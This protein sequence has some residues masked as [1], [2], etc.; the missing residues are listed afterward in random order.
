MCVHYYKYIYLCV[1]IYISSNAHSHMAVYVPTVTSRSQRCWW[2]WSKGAHFRGKIIINRVLHVF[3][4]C[5]W[6]CLRHKESE[7]MIDIST[8]DGEWPRL[9]HTS[10]NSP[11][12]HQVCKLAM[13]I[14]VHN[15]G[16]NLP[17]FL[18]HHHSSLL[19]PSEMAMDMNGISYRPVWE[20]SVL[21]RFVFN[22]YLS[23]TLFLLYDV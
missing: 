14:L 22:T 16:S 13:L 1:Y 3:C 12:W 17:L 9:W 10:A 21:A 23:S 8:R 20:M 6:E 5:I 11:W 19:M 2:E 4:A 18:Q 15:R 7:G